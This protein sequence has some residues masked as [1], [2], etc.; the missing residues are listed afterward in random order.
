M[1]TLKSKVLIV[2][3]CALAIVLVLASS[4]YLSIDAASLSAQMPLK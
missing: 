4:V 2:V 1:D 3:G